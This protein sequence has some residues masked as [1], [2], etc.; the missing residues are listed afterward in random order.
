MKITNMNGLNNAVFA[1]GAQTGLK[2]ACNRLKK[3]ARLNR[4]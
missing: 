3:V 4:V 2:K 1:L